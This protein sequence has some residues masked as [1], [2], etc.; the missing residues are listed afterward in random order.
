M[1]AVVAA[2]PVAEPTPAA[3]AP[4]FARRL[5]RRPLAVVCLS[6]L[7]LVAVVAVV[8]P[9]LLPDV[10]HQ[11]AGDLLAANQ[12]PSGDHLLG[13][14]TV[15][16][17]VLERLLVGT[18][19]TALGVVEAVVV[20]IVLGVSLGLAAGFFGGWID[21]AVTWLADLAFSTPAIAIV[22]VVL[23]VF[24]GSMIAG[25]TTFGVLAAP[26]LMR[27]VRAAT[28]STRQE[29]YVQAAQVAGLSRPYIITRHVLPRIVGPTV[30][31][32]SILAAVALTV[33]TGLAFLHLLVATPAPSWGG[34]VADGTTVLLVN[35]WLIWPAGM[36]I[37]LT[38]LALGLLGD[39]VRDTAVERWSAP[40]ARSRKAAPPLVQETATA[41]I[42]DGALLAVRGLTVGLG[43]TRLVEDVAF[44]IAEG[45][46]VAIVGESGCGKSVTASALIGILARGL[47]VTAGEIRFA[48]RDLARASA[49]E[50]RRVRG[51]E[52]ALISQEPLISL[53]PA[54]TVGSQLTEVV[55][56]H[57]G[58]SRREARR[59]VVELLESVHLPDPDD[60]A[61][62]YPHELSGGMAQ[63]V[64]IARALAGEPRLL[65]ADEPTTALDVTVQAEILDLLRELK[66]SRG[67]SILLITH[68]WGTVADL[69]DRAIVMYAGQV[70]EQSPVSS[71]FT[72]PLHPYTAGLLASDPHRA[73]P[74]ETLPAIEGT[75]PPPGERPQGCHFRPRCGHATDACAVKAIPLLTPAPGRQTRCIHHQELDPA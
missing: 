25:M 30:V 41:D 52:I 14:D 10:A 15:G 21:R 18:R 33:Q 46:S 48:G 67:M 45:E 42:P 66:Y 64:S 51:K 28:L 44:H 23:S 54:F 39:A 26:G 56:R 62:R 17:D 11:Q 72:A 57:H 60:V 12:G 37:A 9:M 55:R 22:I 36:A 31:Q 38:I 58:L 35:P 70:V 74:G 8:A 59:R 13:T 27:V 71:V 75:V 43:D 5:L 47:E 32:V 69:C 16:R 34:M 61:R 20:M 68:D 19:V 2:A 65:I 1:T 63:R 24:P 4:G 3:P 49:K 7:A 73:T 53:D 40:P 50:L 6:Y 29:L